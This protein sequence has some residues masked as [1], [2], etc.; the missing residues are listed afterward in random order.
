MREKGRE[1]ESE[2]KKECV[3]G[4]DRGIQWVDSKKGRTSG[5]RE[6]EREFASRSFLGRCEDSFDL[7]VVDNVRVKMEGSRAAALYCWARKAR[8][9]DYKRARKNG[10]KS[11]RSSICAHVG[12]KLTATPRA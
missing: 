1:R 6:G 10:K 5:E 3:K 11:G 2:R 4:G 12:N 9:D 8:Q 7:K